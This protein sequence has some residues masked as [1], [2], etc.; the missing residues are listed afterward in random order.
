M[1]GILVLSMLCFSP[2]T[3]SYRT[4]LVASLASTRISEERQAMVGL[5][6]F[7]QGALNEIPARG[8]GTLLGSP[9][10]EHEM[11]LDDMQWICQ[12]GPAMLTTSADSDYFVKLAIQKRPWE[13]QATDMA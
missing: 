12:A 4:T 9:S 3:A 5:I 8:Q 13:K 11:P 7:V 10:M 1:I 6:D 2:S